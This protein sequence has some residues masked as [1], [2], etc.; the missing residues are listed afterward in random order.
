M[1]NHIKKDNCSDISY[2]NKV[3]SNTLNGKISS[4]CLTS[5]S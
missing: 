5:Q 3:M 4:Y 1:P 2:Y